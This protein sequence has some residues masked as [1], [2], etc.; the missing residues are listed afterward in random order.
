MSNRGRHRKPKSRYAYS[1][2]SKVLD[3]CI[4][5]KILDT[6]EKYSA[7]NTRNLSVFE[8]DPYAGKYA[9]GFTWSGTEEGSTYWSNILDKVYRY[10]IE[11]KL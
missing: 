11:N 1:W 9:N 8:E 2:I 6:Q 5:N 4:I 10:K 3:D 7:H